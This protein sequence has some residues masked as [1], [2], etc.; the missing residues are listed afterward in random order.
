MRPFVTLQQ[1]SFII[2]WT[3][4]KFL[5]RFANRTSYLIVHCM[6]ASTQVSNKVL[7]FALHYYLKCLRSLRT[8]SHLT[9]LSK[10]RLGRKCEER[11]GLIHPFI[12]LV[13]QNFLIIFWTRPK[14]LQ[15]FA[16]RTSYLIVHC[17]LASTPVSNKIL[18]CA[19]MLQ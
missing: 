13:Q 5:Q 7:G 15:R 10:I 1:K 14:F 8:D 4:P 3:R 9:Q 11:V 19:I 6:L 18:G 12:T 16:N 2:F 17:M